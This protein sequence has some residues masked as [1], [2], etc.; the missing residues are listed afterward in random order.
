LNI[1]EDIRKSTGAPPVSKTP[2]ANFPQKKYL[3]VKAAASVAD[4][5]F[6]D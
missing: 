4:S 1:R 2:L 5:A 3:Y 6:E